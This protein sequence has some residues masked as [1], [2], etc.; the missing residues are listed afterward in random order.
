M[1]SDIE[2]RIEEHENGAHPNS[3]TFKR[4][5]VKLVFFTSFSNP[6]SA[7]EAELKIKNWSRAKKEA[8]IKGEWDKLPNLAK[9]K[10]DK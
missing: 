4:R 7:L 3:Y 5:P 10:F 1:T 6:M 9:K 2:K 8:L